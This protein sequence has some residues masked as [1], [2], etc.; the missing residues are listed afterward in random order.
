MLQMQPKKFFLLNNEIVHNEKKIMR[1]G[2]TL[3]ALKLHAYE[4]DYYTLKKLN[5]KLTAPKVGV[6]EFKLRPRLE[7]LRL[8]GPELRESQEH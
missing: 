4:K 6:T 3:S 8:K 1:C 2:N 7:I 5:Y